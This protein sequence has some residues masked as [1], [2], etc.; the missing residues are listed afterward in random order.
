[1]L[2]GD[3]ME[4]EIRRRTSRAPVT[5]RVGRAAPAAVGVVVAAA[6]MGCGTG[7]SR[8]HPLRAPATAPARG[9]PVA[10]ALRTPRVVFAGSW[11]I[12]PDAPLPRDS[13]WWPVLAVARRFSA[14]DMSYQV[15]ELGPGTRR[16]IVR[17]CTPAFAAEL[18]AH[19][20]VLPPGVTP[21][22]VRQRLVSVRPLERLPG[23]ALVLTAVAGAQEARARGSRGAPVGGGQPGAFEL[24]LVMRARRWQVAAMSVV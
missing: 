23:A 20:A 15:G 17:T 19:R 21:R 12:D 13:A 7:Q 1:V 18:F 14:A 24:R 6:L 22:Q 5:A 9:V 3:R 10:P 16:G 4:P 11:S 8:P 2:T